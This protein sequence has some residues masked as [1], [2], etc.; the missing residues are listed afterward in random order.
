MTFSNAPPPKCPQCGGPTDHYEPLNLRYCEGECGA[1]FDLNDPMVAALFVDG[2]IRSPSDV[3]IRLDAA[4]SLAE[5]D[6]R[7]NERDRE[8]LA[9]CH[10]VGLDHMSVQIAIADDWAA[11][12]LGLKSRTQVRRSRSRLI[13]LGYLS[14][15]RPSEVTMYALRQ[16][17]ETRRADRQ[18]VPVLVGLE[19]GPRSFPKCA[20]CGGD[21][22]DIERVSRRY[23][24]ATCRQRARRS[25]FRTG[26]TVASEAV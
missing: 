14:R 1:Q 23:C 18:R 4:R 25:D 21:I 17:V 9:L 11:R 19:R 7:L 6:G 5:R 8:Y 22:P 15:L 2:R 26:T 3:P 10:D 20:T 12:E 16:W 13:E 24:S